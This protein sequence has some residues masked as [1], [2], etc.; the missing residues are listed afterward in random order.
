MYFIFKIDLIDSVYIVSSSRKQGSILVYTT[1]GVVL[2]KFLF[3]FPYSTS[4]SESGTRISRFEE[5]PFV[6]WL[7]REGATLGRVFRDL[8]WRTALRICASL[9]FLIMRMDSSRSSFFFL[10]ASLFLSNSRQPRLR[11]P[12]ALLL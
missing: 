5:S 6:L 3:F 10:I 1:V 7:L 4:S 8:R 9:I 2:L 11:F 12:A